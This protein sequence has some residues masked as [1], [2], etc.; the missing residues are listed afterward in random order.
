MRYNPNVYVPLIIKRRNSEGMH[1]RLNVHR[2]IW[3][4][5]HCICNMSL[6]RWLWTNNVG[7]F[8]WVICC[9][10]RT[11]WRGP[12]MPRWEAPLL[13]LVQVRWTGPLLMRVE[14]R[15]PLLIWGTTP[16]TPISSSSSVK[17]AAI[18]LASTI[19]NVPVTNLGSI[20]QY[21]M[22]L[23]AL[24]WVEE[25]T[26]HQIQSTKISPLVR[27]R[28]EMLTEGGCIRELFHMGLRKLLF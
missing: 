22:H 14:W 11:R 27:E 6:V 1:S 7:L 21:H 15:R 18:A 28:L 13:M 23:L 5:W 8:A 19:S 3:V 2:S 17:A 25:P 16:T 20:L 12:W 24:K 4:C 10:I 9:W 26:V